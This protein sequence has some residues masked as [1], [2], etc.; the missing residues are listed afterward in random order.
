MKYHNNNL[1][2]SSLQN[3]AFPF[4]L[5]R[6][7]LAIRIP[8]D[9]SLAR[10]TAFNCYNIDKFYDNL[11]SVMDLHKFECHNYNADETGCTTMQQPENVGVK[12]VGSITSGERGQLV[13]VV[14]AVIAAGKIILSKVGL[15]DV[16][17]EPIPVKGLM[18]VTYLKHFI[19][20][21]RCSKEK[22]VLLIL[23]NHKTHVS[24]AAIDLAE[25]NRVISLTISPHTSYKLQ[26][27]DV[28]C[29]KLFKTAYSR[30]VD[31]GMRFH[32][33]KSI[34]IY[35]IP[36]F[37]SHAQIHG[38]TAQNIIYGFQRTRIYPF[39]QDEFCKT[40]LTPAVVTDGDL[41]TSFYENQADILKSSLKETPISN[42]MPESPNIS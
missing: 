17:E 16:S 34:T 35:D 19:T 41:P 10:A 8:E 2:Q 9:T 3:Q 12:Q 6:N 30:V 38:L 13:A 33:G 23:D 31:N 26:P 21:T 22:K 28:S 15:Q 7:H 1:Q 27:L 4:C 37:V 25:K 20:Y 32:P 14:Y 18:F 5:E 42:S 11:K 29:Y 36:E 40:E 39:N 24:L